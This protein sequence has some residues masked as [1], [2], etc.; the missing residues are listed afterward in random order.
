LFSGGIV[1]GKE[2]RG[3]TFG[4]DEGKLSMIFPMTSEENVPSRHRGRRR[5]R[6]SKGQVL[7]NWQGEKR[8][9]GGASA[10]FSKEGGGVRREE[11]SMKRGK[12]GARWRDVRG[13]LGGKKRTF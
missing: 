12:T 2:K 13:G 6:C 9:W 7:S 3:E 8:I 4:L 1:T 10:S 11:T 5:A